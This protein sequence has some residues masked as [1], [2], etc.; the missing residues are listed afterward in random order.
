M[1]LIKCPECGKEISDRAQA[2]INCGCPIS[3]TLSTSGKIMVKIPKLGL[4]TLKTWKID[5]FNT[6]GQKLCTVVEGSSAV[7]N[8]DK[9]M[10][11]F[12]QFS[13]SAI[14]PCRSE[15]FMIHANKV[16]RIQVTCQKNF[17]GGVKRLV[18]SEIDIIDSE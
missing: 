4:A 18:I 3:N 13:K 8:I 1:A 14:S 12:A 7:L 11:I 9:D 10:E 5:I 6:V 16:N 2:C 17:L 15:N